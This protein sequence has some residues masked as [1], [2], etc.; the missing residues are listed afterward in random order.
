MDGYTNNQIGRFKKYYQLKDE[1]LK[2]LALQ[3]TLRNFVTQT[4][5]VEHSIKSYHNRNLLLQNI[6]SLEG[7]LKLEGIS[8]LKLRKINRLLKGFDKS[9]IDFIS[10]YFIKEFNKLDIN[11]MVLTDLKIPDRQQLN[12]IIEYKRLKSKRAKMSISPRILAKMV[13]RRFK[14]LYYTL[15]PDGDESG[16]FVFIND[17]MDK[18]EKDETYVPKLIQKAKEFNPNYVF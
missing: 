12:D 18:F 13:S 2:Y 7:S 8:I 3:Q 16:A 10:Q 1:I 9:H 5:K 14:K 6:K 15:N 11:S 17:T 4:H